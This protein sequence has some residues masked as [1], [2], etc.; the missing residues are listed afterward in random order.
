M[1]EPLLEA[2]YCKPVARLTLSDRQEI[3]QTLIDFHCYMKPK[4][5]MDQ[6]MEGLDVLQVASFIKSH[7]ALME[8]LF[9]KG[10]SIPL[11]PGKIFV[12]I[13]YTTDVLDVSLD[14]IR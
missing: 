8:P 13:T 3:I 2:N 7:P 14:D 11:S 6:F 10:C 12:Y 5:C 1:L 9:V 4:A